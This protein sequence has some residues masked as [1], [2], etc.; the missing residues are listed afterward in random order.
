MCMGWRRSWGGVAKPEGLAAYIAAHP[1]RVHG[2]VKLPVTSRTRDGGK[3]ARGGE[4]AGLWGWCNVTHV[5]VIGLVDDWSVATKR[6]FRTH[7]GGCRIECMVLPDGSVC[8]PTQRFGAQR[9]VDSA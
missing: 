7:P 6:H 3:A 4:G 9:P 5:R 8:P 1:E 2:G